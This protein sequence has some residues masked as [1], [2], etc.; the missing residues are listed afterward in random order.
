MN[1]KPLMGRV[2]I[3][4]IKSEKVGSLIVVESSKDKSSRGEILAIGTFE[5]DKSFDLKIGDVVIFP[6]WGGTMV[7]S[8][9]DDDLIILKAEEIL[10]VEAN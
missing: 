4:K 1:I 10:G 2:L 9:L 6:T 7:S 5:K 8:A 3:K